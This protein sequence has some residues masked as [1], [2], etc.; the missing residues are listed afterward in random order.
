MKREDLF[1]KFD[2]IG[3]KHIDPDRIRIT[4]IP[5]R[6][7]GTNLKAQTPCVCLTVNDRERGTVLVRLFTPAVTPNKTREEYQAARAR[8]VQRLKQIRTLAREW[9]ALVEMENTSD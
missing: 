1:I 7:K 5:V 3:V 2:E 8:S 9:L 6:I 4:D